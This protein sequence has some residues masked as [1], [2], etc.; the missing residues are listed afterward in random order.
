MT[1]QLD[2]NHFD[3]VRARGELRMVVI[4]VFKGSSAYSTAEG[5]AATTSETPMMSSSSLPGN[6]FG[7]VDTSKDIGYT[8]VIVSVICVTLVVCIVALFIHKFL[9]K[10]KGSYDTREDL[11]PELL[12]F[13]NH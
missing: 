4:A 12:Q 9:Q 11:K 3:P 10:R 5:K 6:L 1:S 7:T 13:Q 8:P 2:T